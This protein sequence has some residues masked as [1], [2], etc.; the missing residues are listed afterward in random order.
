MAVADYAATA[1]QRLI[2][3]RQR[4]HANMCR[5]EEAYQNA[6]RLYREASTPERRDRR[7]EAL[8]RFA[9]HADRYESLTS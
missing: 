8:R 7:D 4:A 2:V 3:R 6:E 5:A 9:F 1:T